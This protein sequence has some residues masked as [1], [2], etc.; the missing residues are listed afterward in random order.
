[1]TPLRNSA[2]EKGDEKHSGDGDRGPGGPAGLLITSPVTWSWLL[3]L[4]LGTLICQAK[5]TVPFLFTSQCLEIE[6]IIRTKV[7]VNTLPYNTAKY[8]PSTERY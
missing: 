8:K 3:N 7:F 1:M 6:E 5:V 2:A 4:Y